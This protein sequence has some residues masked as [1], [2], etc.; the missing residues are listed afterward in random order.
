M[1]DSNFTRGMSRP[2]AHLQADSGMG[3][4]HFAEGRGTEA[5]PTGTLHI[6]RKSCTDEFHNKQKRHGKSGGDNAAAVLVMDRKRQTYIE[7]GTLLK[8][9][10]TST[11]MLETSMGEKIRV[12]SARNGIPYTTAGDKS[13]PCPEYSVGFY[14]E[15]SVPSSAAWATSVAREARKD[16]TKHAGGTAVQPPMRMT[17]KLRTQLETYEQDMDDVGA[18]PQI[19]CDE[20]DSDE[21]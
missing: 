5:G 13:Y 4:V 12:T 15:Y 19:A 16:P 10:Q 14:D 20:E 9:N 7:D 2:G 21:D 17:W 8:H 6:E 1:D 3:K 18:L 11:T